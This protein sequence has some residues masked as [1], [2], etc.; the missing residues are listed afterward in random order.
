MR[1]FLHRVADILDGKPAVRR[2]NERGQSVVEMALFTPILIIMVVGM[3][4]I[5]WYANNYIN[6]LEAAKVGARRGP[7]LNA[8]NAP[9][10]WP[11]AAWITHPANDLTWPPIVDLGFTLTDA[12]PGY[13]NHPRI[14]TRDCETQEENFGFFNIVACT[15]LDSLEPLE[16]RENGKDDI[17]VSVFALHRVAV[18]DGVA[19]DIDID[20]WTP[21]SATDYDDGIQM[22]V[23]G[24]YPVE[25]NECV[26]AGGNQ[27][28]RDPFDYI[29]N[30]VVDWDPAVPIPGSGGLTTP[31]VFELSP[32]TTTGEPA[33]IPGTGAQTGYIDTG[34]ERARGFLWTGQRVVQ[35]PDMIDEDT[36]NPAGFT[37]Y[38]SAWSSTEVQELMNLP[39]FL[40]DPDDADETTFLTNQALVLVE[41]YWE[42]TLLLEGFPLLSGRF[43][44]VYFMLGGDDPNSVADVIYV[45]SAFPVPA[46]EPSIQY[47]IATA[48]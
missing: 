1:N 4:E 18:G 41:V 7:F 15:V 11:P 24:R 26:S 17:V 13:F 21:A 9:Q 43:S 25:A 47:T 39:G 38:G 27:L 34:E 37:C 8:E 40:L 10:N 48:P 36:G 33:I 22:V 45:W 19:D 30:G 35:P 3:V 2:R 44:P 12:D 23:V 42:H 5:G 32:L 6:L 16:I 29:E 28:E 46:A 20:T 14:V 31:L